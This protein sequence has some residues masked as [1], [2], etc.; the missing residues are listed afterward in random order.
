[1]V[2]VARGRRGLFSWERAA[3]TIAAAL[4]RALPPPPEPPGAAALTEV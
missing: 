4:R 3:E 1:L 2:E